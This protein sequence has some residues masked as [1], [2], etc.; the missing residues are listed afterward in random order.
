[1]SILATAFAVLALQPG[2]TWTLYEG[3]GPLVLAHEIPD[4]PR[5]RAV[6]ECEPGAGV[7]RLDLY[8][9]GGSGGIATVASGDTTA[10]TESVGVADHRSLAL[11]A[12]HP[13][14]G[15]FV[16]TGQLAVTVAGRSQAVEVEAA[17]LAKLRRFAELCGG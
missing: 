2:W 17:H 7:A 10:Q 1:M 12:D 5:L 15:Q 8:D 4:T 3:D 13:V 11:R 16:L 14:F 9:S 6:L